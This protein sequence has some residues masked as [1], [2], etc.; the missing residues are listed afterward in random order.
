[1]K[2]RLKECEVAPVAIDVVSKSE[3]FLCLS[4]DLSLKLICGEAAF[5]L[6]PRGFARCR[7][8]SVDLANGPGLCLG[9]AVFLDLPFRELIFVLCFAVK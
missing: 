6:D 7:P 8:R 5:Q 1:M 3:L 9:I 2:D 4:F